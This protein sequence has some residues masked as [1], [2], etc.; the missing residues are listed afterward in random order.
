MK[1]SHSIIINLPRQ[2]VVELF[3]SEENLAKWQP[4]FVSYRHLSGKPGEK[5]AQAL[6]TYKM[7]RGETEMTE[8]I[9]LNDFPNSFHSTYDARGVHNIQENYFKEIGKDQTEW[10]SVSEF[11]FS[12]LMMRA[13]GWLMPGAFKKQSLKF[14]E[15][16]KEFAEGEG[17]EV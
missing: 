13:M 6:L 7:G 11:R 10:T 17:A 3:D 8:T 4:G 14:M 5:G 1:Y 15:K 2:R 16:F 12:N 9:I